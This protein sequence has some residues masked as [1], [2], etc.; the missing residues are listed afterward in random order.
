MITKELVMIMSLKI[1]KVFQTLYERQTVS[2]TVLIIVS[3]LLSV[4]MVFGSVMLYSVYKMNLFLSPA[5]VFRRCVA[6]QR[7][8][9][10]RASFDPSLPS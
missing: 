5:G 4:I 9:A 1:W 6:S 7:L 2:F 8:S 3:K 10:S